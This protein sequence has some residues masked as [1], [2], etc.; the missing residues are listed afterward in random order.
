LGKK[1]WLKKKKKCFPGASG[2]HEK[3]G[4]IYRGD[5]LVTQKQRPLNDPNTTRRGKLAIRT[6][7]GEKKREQNKYKRSARLSR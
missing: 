3:E 5:E 4:K 7:W 1:T 2:K 6:K